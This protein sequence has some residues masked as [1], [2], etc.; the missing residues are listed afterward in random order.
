MCGFQN[1]HISLGAGRCCAL[2]IQMDDY[3]KVRFYKQGFFFFFLIWKTTL[4]YKYCIFFTLVYSS[5]H[6]TEAVAV[7]ELNRNVK[8]AFLC[9][10]GKQSSL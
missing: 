5:P 4:I 2:C 1:Q 8:N 6:L 3:F 10:L 9:H 7:T